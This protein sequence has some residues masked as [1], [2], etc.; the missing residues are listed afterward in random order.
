MRAVIHD[1]DDEKATAI[2]KACRRAMR[3]GARLLL[4]ERVVEAPNDGLLTKFSDLNMLVSP[5]GLERTYDEYSTL[6]RR[7]DIETRGTVRAGPQYQIIEA[8]AV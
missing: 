5:G 7:A 2:L 8:V 6:C 1:W 4:I 3:A